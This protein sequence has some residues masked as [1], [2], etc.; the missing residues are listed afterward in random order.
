[1][2]TLR[3]C[4]RS[5]WSVGIFRSLLVLTALPLFAN[6]QVRPQNVSRL[7][8]TSPPDSIAPAAADAPYRF[9]GRVVNRG[10]VATGPLRAGPNT[11]VVQVDSVI[12]QPA[13]VRP[14][15]NQTLTLVVRDTAGIVNNGSY[16]VLA[17]AIALGTG[18]TL[19]E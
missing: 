6:G 4:L 10:Q 13:M 18:L 17:N 3:G 19:R 16:V 12:A 11:M 2:R 8:P 15:K 14:M 7:V 5:R 1:M 9:L